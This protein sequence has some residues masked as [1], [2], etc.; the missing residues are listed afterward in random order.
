MQRKQRKC[1]SCGVKFSPMNSMQVVCGYKCASEFAKKK[2]A[3]DEENKE[4]LK[5]KE[6]RER[7][8]RLDDTVPNWTKKAQAAFNKYIRIRDRELPCVSC[9][10]HEHELTTIGG[11]GGVW[12]CGHYRSVGSCPELRF[13]PLNAH[14]QCKRCNNFLS[15]NHI[16]YRF[17]IAARL[18][19]EELEWV[20]GPHE[21]KRYRVD[22]LKEITKKYKGLIKEL[23]NERS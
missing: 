10:K 16:E 13:E 5:K 20:E 6:L 18:T 7:K 3:K 4:R 9:G 2:L 12:D 11:M 21:Q 22:E 14:K 19:T 15:G 1:K 8:K 17:G 23:E